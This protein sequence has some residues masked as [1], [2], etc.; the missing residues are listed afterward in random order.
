MNDR[1]RRIGLTPGRAVVVAA[2][3]VGLFAVWGP[4]VVKLVSKPGAGSTPAAQ[5]RHSAIVAAPPARAPQN[6]APASAPKKERTERALPVC[7]VAEA[8]TYDP[9]AAPAWSPSAS[10]PASGAG[11]AASDESVA[12][13]FESLR[14][15][16]VA[17]VFVSAAG[18]A[19]QVGDKTLRVGDRID[20]FEV[21]GIDAAGVV[22]R[23]APDKERRGDHG[24]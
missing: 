21:V 11:A 19:A 8:A 20:G 13:R 22:L 10:D 12:E 15:K 14:K 5:S 3:G 7:S 16:G 17:M 9:F 2:L 1:L 23:P 18:E 4:Q 24:A 6:A